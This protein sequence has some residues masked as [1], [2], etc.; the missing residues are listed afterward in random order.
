MSA[1]TVQQIRDKIKTMFQTV[2]GIGNVHTY[3]RYLKD[4]SKLV[5]LYKD[6]TS[7]RLL[8]WHIR[9]V[10]T[11]ENYI[12]ISRW[13]VDHDWKIRGFMSLDDADAT[14]QTFDTLIESIRDVFRDDPSLGGLIFSTVIEEKNN[15]A[16]V[17]VEEA[18]PVLFAGVLCHSAR[19]ALTTRHL[20]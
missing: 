2:T 16:G 4:Q 3:E 8:G 17:Q 6:A 5:S 9:K 19:L 18:V 20:I 10:A 1:P 13:V 15:Q 7:G 12:D 14:E 11:R